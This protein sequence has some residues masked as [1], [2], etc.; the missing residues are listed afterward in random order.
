MGEYYAMGFSINGSFVRNLRTTRRQAAHTFQQ[1]GFTG[2]PRAGRAAGGFHGS[3]ARTRSLSCH[4]LR[5]CLA[6][7]YDLAGPFVAFVARFIP[8]P[9]CLHLREPSLLLS[10]H[11]F[12]LLRSTALYLER[13][14]DAWSFFLDFDDRGS[15]CCFLCLD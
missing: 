14:S 11:A 3:P 9:P 15:Q 6:A 12:S 2:S 7:V 8:P 1:R 4:R 5:V 10:N 13:N